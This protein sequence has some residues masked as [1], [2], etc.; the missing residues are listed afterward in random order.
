MVTR[1]R[2]TSAQRLATGERETATPHGDS[3][4]GVR[5]ETVRE[6]LCLA[7]RPAVRFRN[8]RPEDLQAARAVVAAWRQ[9]NPAGTTEQLIDAV[10]AQF[11]DD[12]GPVL[13]AVLYVV[14]KHAARAICG[15]LSGTAGASR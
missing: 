10:G 12:W 15:I 3:E 1:L 9:Q 8:E 2:A 14:D 4:G 5:H 13:R 11:R 6:T 7:R